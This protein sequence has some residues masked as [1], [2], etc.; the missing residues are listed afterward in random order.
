MDKENGEKI[1]LL[2]MGG[3]CVFNGVWLEFNRD[4]FMEVEIQ[5]GGPF[6]PAMANSDGNRAWRSNRF[7]GTPRGEETFKLAEPMEVAR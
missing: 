5:G 6:R 3:S 1:A 2:G 4:D 7:A